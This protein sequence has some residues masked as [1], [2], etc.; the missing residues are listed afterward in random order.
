MDFESAFGFDAG[1]WG[2]AIIAFLRIATVLFFLPIF[3][4]EG[5]PLRVRI[6]FALTI[7][8]ATWPVVEKTISLQP[9]VADNGATFLFIVTLKE[10]LVGFTIGF[11]CKLLIFA[12]S[13]G[14]NIIGVNMGFQT[15]AFLNPSLQSQDSVFSSFKNWIVLMLIFA[16]NIHHYFIDIIFRSFR[17]VPIMAPVNRSLLLES[18]IYLGQMCFEIGLRIAAPFIA[19]QLIT[20]VA[21]GLLG[22][23][24][25]QLQVFIINFPLSYLISMILLF[26]A[27][28]SIATV[29]THESA[30]SGVAIS[31]KALQALGS[32]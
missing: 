4:S 19:I 23:L 18:I 22:R 11:T 20:T 12:A 1:N 27:L 7:T 13:I 15:A 32:K 28:A 6:L 16:L 21:L 14:A 31:E 9:N 26:F 2:L 10:L 3:G 5:T 29:I 17:M 8:F 25:P 24:V 30:K